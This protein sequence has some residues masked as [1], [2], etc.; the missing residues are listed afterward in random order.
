MLQTPLFPRLHR[1]HW[2]VPY[3]S[4]ADRT[5][6]PALLIPLLNPTDDYLKIVVSQTVARRI[7]LYSPITGDFVS[8]TPSN[9]RHLHVRGH[10]SALNRIVSSA[11]PSLP[12]LEVLYIDG[13]ISHPT[14]L[15]LSAAGRLKILNIRASSDYPHPQFSPGDS[16]P[17]LEDLT[18]Q[19]TSDVMFTVLQHVSSP[20]FEALSIQPEGSQGFDP[21]M[22]L[23]PLQFPTLRQ[24]ILRSSTTK[25]L[26]VTP[27]YSCRALRHVQLFQPP[28]NIDDQSIE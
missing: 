9:L 21:L 24:F 1:L 10:N 27:L 26:D 8:L 17:S 12:H 13:T 23:I 22:R 15:Y 20:C 7:P 3:P 4:P 25:N 18:I 19:A 2:V 5:V 11:F 6:E 28:V 14:L 16:F